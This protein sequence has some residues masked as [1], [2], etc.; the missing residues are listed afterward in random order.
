MIHFDFILGN[1]LFHKRKVRVLDFN[2]CGWG[3]FLYGL[4]PLLGNLRD[5][6]EY[7][8]LRWA[9]LAGYRSVRPLPLEWEEAFDMLMAARHASQCL[10][11]A[12]SKRN[13]GM[14]PDVKEH[15]AYRMEEIRLIHKRRVRLTNEWRASNVQV[16]VTHSCAPQVAF[17]RFAQFG[18]SHVAW[19]H[20]SLVF[21]RR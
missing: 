13:G 16:G 20:A 21:E 18:A 3:Y 5:Y 4:C 1:C 19:P 14:G 9:F 11:I 6:P 8:A 15:V 10:W 12:G 17:V 7:P 2:D